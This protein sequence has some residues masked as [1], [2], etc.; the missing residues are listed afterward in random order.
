MY[1]GMF[2]AFQRMGTPLWTEVGSAGTMTMA[3]FS[4]Q[5]EHFLVPLL[6]EP[7]ASASTH[8]IPMSEC[9]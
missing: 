3:Y 9:W 8:F 2:V 7:R 5:R 6:A 1:L 4:F